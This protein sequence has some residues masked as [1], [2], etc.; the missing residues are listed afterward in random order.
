M[1]GRRETRGVATA[2]ILFGVVFGILFLACEQREEKPDARTDAPA[3]AKAKSDS[4]PAPSASKAA[5][6]PRMSFNNI[7]SHVQELGEQIVGFRGK[8]TEDLE[9]ALGE[10]E[11]KQAQLMTELLR[12]GGENEKWD[13]AS[14]ELVPRAHDLRGRVQEF[15]RQCARCEQ[16]GR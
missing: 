5:A 8:A 11:A 4:P 12:I 13:A 6:R 7:R 9:V 3:S 1:R 16:R 14:K 2:A 15:R 10:L